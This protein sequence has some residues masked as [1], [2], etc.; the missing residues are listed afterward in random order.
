[1]L[2]RSVEFITRHLAVGSLSRSVGGLGLAPVQHPGCL[3]PG[4]LCNLLGVF[5][6]PA[7]AGGQEGLIQSGVCG[8]TLAGEGCPGV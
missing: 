8:K 6:V 5:Q 2:T 1:M 7:R 3:Q 4:P